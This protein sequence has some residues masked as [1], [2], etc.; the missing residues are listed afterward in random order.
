M[1]HE[2]DGLS[3]K[4]Q[5]L[6]ADLRAEG[7]VEI[8][9]ATATGVIVGFPDSGAVAAITH[10]DRSRDDKFPDLGMNKNIVHVFSASVA[11]AARLLKAPDVLFNDPAERL[12]GRSY[13]EVF[14]FLKRYTVDFD[15]AISYLAD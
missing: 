8:I 4:L 12:L 14:S 7:K 11:V 1:S 2:L 10:I 15:S 13:D 6:V 9:T 5:E 3:P